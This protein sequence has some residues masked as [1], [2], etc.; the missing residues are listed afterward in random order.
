MIKLP[1]IEVNKTKIDSLE[2]RVSILEQDRKELS[3]LSTLME[4]QVDMN[5]EQ[6]IFLREQSLTLV[7]MNE[8]LTSLTTETSKLGTRLGTLE[9][10]IVEERIEGLRSEAVNERSN[11]INV[12]HLLKHVVATLVTSAIIAGTIWIA[13]T[14]R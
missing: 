4:I 5:K 6:D 14:M 3:K 7:K 11:S 13:T 2:K 10:K 8:N 9:D 12:P 1:E